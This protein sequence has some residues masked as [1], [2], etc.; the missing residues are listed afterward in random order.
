MIANRSRFYTDP[1][2]VPGGFY[3]GSIRVLIVPLDIFISR[4][5]KGSFLL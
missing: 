3:K 1:A 4:D 5:P 2:V